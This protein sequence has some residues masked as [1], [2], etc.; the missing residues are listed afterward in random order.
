VYDKVRQ[1]GR[2]YM[3]ELQTD[4]PNM[5]IIY[6]FAYDFIENW[7]NGSYYAQEYAL[8]KPFLDG[9]LEGAG[10]QITLIDGNEA[11]YFT[12]K[13]EDHTWWYDQ[14]ETQYLKDR[15]PSE[16]ATKY[17]QQYRTGYASVVNRYFDIPYGQAG[18]CFN[19]G[20]SLE[21]QRKWTEH[22]IF[23]RLLNTD[24][25]VWTWSQG[26][27]DWWKK[28]TFK[29]KDDYANAI[30]AAK[31][32]LNA[33]QNLGY[34]MSYAGNKL[35][36]DI[37]TSTV[38]ATMEFPTHN[39]VVPV[40]EVTFKVKFND[41][42]K[43]NYQY[44]Y[45]N[46]MS[47][48]YT[49]SDTSK[50]KLAEGIYTAYVFGYDKDN[51]SYQSNPVTFTV[52]TPTVAD[53]QAPTAPASLSAT[54]ITQTGFST[55][56]SAATDNISVVSYVVFR[57][58]ILVQN[59]QSTNFSF[60]GLT[61]NTTYNITVKARDA[62]GNIS[63]ASTAL[64]VK[65]LTATTV[66]TQAPSTPT[67][68]SASNITTNSFTATWTAS[69]DNV[70]VVSYDVFR[71]GVLTQ[72]TQSTNFAFTGLTANTTYNVTVKARDAAGNISA[73]GQL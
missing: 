33:G 55:T 5:K 15:I 41:A 31:A 40:G 71:D 69:T 19:F 30:I 18:Y 61:A 10:P 36:A 58:G 54:N 9:M 39:S 35:K 56:W 1:R 72:N 60:T 28:T 17:K 43:N 64:S 4:V 37:S 25:Y 20:F 65:T 16:L 57:D 38:V 32:K 52:G 42:T 24:E 6:T 13:N 51:K 12:D 70:G 21:T 26:D 23:N 7:G 3:T 29:N 45:I 62:A 66:D 63:A 46:S 53:T 44:F 49:L 34:T 22:S 68:I 14:I 59:T 27:V 50:L 48:G 8:L 47:K 73:A 2:E 11:T 67:N